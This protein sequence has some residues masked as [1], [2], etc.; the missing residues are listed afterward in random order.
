MT[1][2]TERQ[3]L[4]VEDAITTIATAKLA[5][6][7]NDD[8]IVARRA[9]KMIEREI[10]SLTDAANL[11]DGESAWYRLQGFRD[12]DFNAEAAGQEYTP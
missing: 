6:I 11:L 9:E 12:R 4:Y 1:S 3:R 5:D 7:T 8:T 10:E 2:L